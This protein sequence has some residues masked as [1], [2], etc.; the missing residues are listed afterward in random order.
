M[1]VMDR[2]REREREGDS[3]CTVIVE[4]TTYTVCLTS[5]INQLREVL[6]F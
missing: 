2:E 3:Y 5:E 6:P 4:Q 1:A